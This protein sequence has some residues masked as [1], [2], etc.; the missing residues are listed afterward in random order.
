MM[1]LR[2]KL[3]GASSWELLRF[4]QAAIVNTIFG[5]SLYALLVYLGLDRYV[6]QIS[7][8]IVGMC[9]NYLTYSRHV[10]RNN[11]SKMGFVLSY[12]FSGVCNFG[13]LYLISTFVT[14]PYQAGI[15]ATLLTS[16]ITYFI[17]KHSVFAGTHRRA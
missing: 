4:Y 14:S 9:F 8:H 2:E 10:F 6:A 3:F 1:E 7:S 12:L 15:A 16:L 5:L 13:L 11:G 17:L